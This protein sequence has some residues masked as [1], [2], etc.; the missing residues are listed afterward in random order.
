MNEMN[1]EKDPLSTDADVGG[2]ANLMEQC[3]STN[4]D[5]VSEV[6][7]IVADIVDAISNTESSPIYFDPEQDELIENKTYFTLNFYA[8]KE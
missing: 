8:A 4:N 3:T 7:A 2:L 1:K 5:P 6:K